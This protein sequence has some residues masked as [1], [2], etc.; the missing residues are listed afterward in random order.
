MQTGKYKSRSR[1]STSAP[2]LAGKGVSK[3]ME[4]QAINAFAT[5]KKEKGKPEERYAAK[6]SLHTFRQHQTLLPEILHLTSPHVIM[7][8]NAAV[9]A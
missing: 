9:L 1:V 7:F 8:W 6:F 5:G 2:R 4:Y 3:H